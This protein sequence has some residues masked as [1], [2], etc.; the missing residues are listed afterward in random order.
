MF[1]LITNHPVYTSHPWP[2]Y[3]HVQEITAVLITRLS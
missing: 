1:E 2:C 3:R